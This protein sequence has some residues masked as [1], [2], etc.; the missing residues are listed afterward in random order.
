MNVFG[1]TYEL[2]WSNTTRRPWTY[3]MRQWSRQN[4]VARTVMVAL[5]LALVFFA[6]SAI[7]SWSV[8]FWSLAVW[9]TGT[10]WGHLFWDT[11][12]GHVKHAGDF[13]HH[14]IGR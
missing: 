14:E 13:E 10:I 11:A 1:R 7:W 6:A 8:G 3:V 4:R 9:G 12:G 5:Y 2:L